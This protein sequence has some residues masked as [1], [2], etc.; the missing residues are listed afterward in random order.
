MKTSTL[1]V[2]GICV[3]M[4]LLLGNFDMT[5]DFFDTPGLQ[6]PELTPEQ[7]INLAVKSLELSSLGWKTEQDQVAGIISTQVYI[8]SKLREINNG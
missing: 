7:E 2:I 8:N 6:E 1:F 5:K 3:G 4:I